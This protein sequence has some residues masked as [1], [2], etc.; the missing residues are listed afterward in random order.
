MLI[1]SCNEY[2]KL[3]KSTD[4][5]LKYEAAVKYYNEGDYYKAFSLLD[6]LMT[7]YNGTNKAQDIYWMLS[8]C[9]Y[10]LT[11]YTLAATRFEIFHKRYPLS[12]HSEEALYM[13]A[14][15]N[16]KNSPE[17]TLDQTD[18]KKAIN[19]LQLFTDK[20]PSNPRVDTC[21]FLIEKLRDKLET[22]QYK[23]S[24]LYYHTENYKAAI[25]AFDNLL[26]DFPD[27]ERKE[28]VLFYQLESKALL[29][30]NSI[31]SKKLK[32]NMDVIDS[33]TKFV[34]Q[35]PSSTHLK[36]AEGLYNKAKQYV[37]INEQKNGS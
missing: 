18:T 27:T 29:A 30:Q 21:N 24:Y 10:H 5:N 31:L 17:L 4:H 33:Y 12:E 37:Q 36:S 32:R 28:K 7:V 26:E 1:T 35:Y 34:D 8:W 6:N 16:Y 23:Q 22:K 15:S 13:S 3:L 2:G 14:L 11:D 9:D 19:G 20:Y 25:V